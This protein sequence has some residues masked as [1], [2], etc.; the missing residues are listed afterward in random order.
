MSDIV[1][2]T[3]SIANQFM[4]DNISK[5]EQMVVAFEEPMSMESNPVTEDS[6]LS[7]PAASVESSEGNMLSDQKKEPISMVDAELLNNLKNS[8]DHISHPS[9]FSIVPETIQQP[10]MQ[11]PCASTAELVQV[12]LKLSQI[13][14]TS[15]SMFNQ[16]ILPVLDTMN[17]LQSQVNSIYGFLQSGQTINRADNN[18]ILHSASTSNRSSHSPPVNSNIPAKEPKANRKRKNESEDD[19]AESLKKVELDQHN[20]LPQGCDQTETPL[21]ILSAISTLSKPQEEVD[22]STT[23]LSENVLIPQPNLIQNSQLNQLS[24]FNNLS[25]VGMGSLHENLAKMMMNGQMGQFQQQQ[26]HLMPANNENVLGSLA[27][28]VA[29]PKIKQKRVRKKTAKALTTAE[30]VNG[31]ETAVKVEANLEEMEKSVEVKSEVVGDENGVM[32]EEEEIKFT[33]G[34]GPSSCNNC[35]TEAT[36][37]WRRDCMG[38]LVCN[39]CGLYFRL[40]KTPRPAHLRKDKI[41]SRYRKAK[42]GKDG[43][44]EGKA[45]TPKADGG[46][47]AVN[48]PTPLFDSNIF[49]SS[50]FNNALGGFGQVPQLENAFPMYNNQNLISNILMNSISNQA[51]QG[52]GSISD[53]FSSTIPKF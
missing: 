18:S 51:Q 31:A 25:A 22:L 5:D 12:K 26:Q 2:S 46:A 38:N 44:G 3:S 23:M 45:V 47:V 30:N 39:A 8:H 21:S 49:N 16:Y 24:M 34:E 27:E 52:Q 20:S 29:P 36:T 11:C 37:A 53:L 13:E 9:A 1:I 10:Q 17:S 33:P 32:G 19:H 35:K 6:P 42:G 41:Q 7:S 50:F 43:K 15:Q 14:A 48:E 28:M 4:Q 40:H